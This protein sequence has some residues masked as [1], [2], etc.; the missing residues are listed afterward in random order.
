ML[1]SPGTSPASIWI[2]RSASSSAKS[3]VCMRASGTRPDSIRRIAASYA[4]L[5][6]PNAP[7]IVISFTTIRSL[8]KSGTG[9]KPFTPASTTRPRVAT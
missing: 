2:A 6:T 3:C 7:M 9:L 5:V 4:R 8:T 1:C